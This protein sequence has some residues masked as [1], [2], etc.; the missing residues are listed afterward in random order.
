MPPTEY[1][2]LRDR[3]QQ[4]QESIPIR[5]ESTGDVLDRLNP[6]E[7]EAGWLHSQTHVQLQHIYR[8]PAELLKVFHHGSTLASDVRLDGPSYNR[9][10]GLFGLVPQQ[11]GVPKYLEEPLK[12]VDNAPPVQ[13][14]YDMNQNRRGSGQFGGFGRRDGRSGGVDGDR[15]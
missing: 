5:C 11:R 6:L 1:L 7:L 2:R 12:T 9:L 14:S 3:G 10:M 4:F 13:G 8:V 15:F